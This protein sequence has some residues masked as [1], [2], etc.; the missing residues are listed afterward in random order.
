MAADIPTSDLDQWV[1]QLSQCKYLPEEQLK[2]LC[3]RVRLPLSHLELAPLTLS[4][5]LA[6]PVHAIYPRNLPST[7]FEC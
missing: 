3:E 7:M 6:C 4:Q 2:L 1:E 5:D